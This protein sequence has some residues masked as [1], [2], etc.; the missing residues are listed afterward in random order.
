[1]KQEL[2]SAKYRHEYK[3]MNDAAQNAV[4]KTRAK[5]I[6]RQ[7]KYAGSSGSYWVRSL[8]FDSPY[9][10]C[11]YENED[12][13]GVRAKYRIR[14][15]NADCSHITLEKKSKN[16]QMT[17]KQSCSIDETICRQ[18]MTQQGIHIT[19]DM[20][21]EL[22][23]LLC[24]MQRRCMRPAVIVEYLRYPFVDPNGNVRI[25]FDENICSSNDISGFLEK[26]IMTRPILE[27]GMSVLEVKW[28]EFLPGYIKNHMQLE[29]LQ[30]QSFSKYY[31]CRRYNIYGGVK[32]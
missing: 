15:Y 24:E 9:D 16:R 3:Y 14:I 25:T 13:V 19:P 27:K 17:L 20:A 29:T 21:D 8:Y 22:K 31:L 4:L 7:D 11:Y 1:M 30:W 12:G 23:Y 26:R 18:L 10:D 6:L 2:I 28:D 32:I 5:A